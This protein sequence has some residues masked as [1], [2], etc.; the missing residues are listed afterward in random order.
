MTWIW[1]YGN[2]NK[3]Y[4]KEML[5]SSVQIQHKPSHLSWSSWFIKKSSQ[6]TCSMKK[7]VL[8]NFLEFTAQLS[9]NG[10]FK[11]KQ[12]RRCSIKKDVLKHFAK[13]IGKHLCRSVFLTKLQILY[14]YSFSTTHEYAILHGRSHSG[15]R[16]I[17]SPSPHFNFCTKQVPQFW[18]QT[19]GIFHDY[20]RV[21]YSFCTNY[22]GFLSFITTYGK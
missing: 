16:G 13:F 14:K 18:F 8:K 11:K 20:Y 22:G 2:I 21:C 10:W 15:A 9:W 17:M 3:K 6:G 7:S 19:M 1:K 5:S 12:H 4:T